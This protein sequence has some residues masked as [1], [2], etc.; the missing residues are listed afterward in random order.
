MSFVTGSAIGDAPFSAPD[1]ALRLE[2]KIQTTQKVNCARAMVLGG[3]TILP[4]WRTWRTPTRI[5]TLWMGVRPSSGA[6]SV[7]LRETHRGFG[8]R[9]KRALPPPGA[10]ALREAETGLTTTERS[11]APSSFM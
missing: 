7:E 1:T 5:K 9:D 6:A 3:F 2:V 4:A 10:G 11:F 8:P